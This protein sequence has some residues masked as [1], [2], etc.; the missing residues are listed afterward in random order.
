MNSQVTPGTVVNV[1]HVMPL[2]ESISVTIGIQCPG[3]KYSDFQWAK[4][5]RDQRLTFTDRRPFFMDPISIPPLSP[6]NC[7]VPD[8]KRM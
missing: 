1:L 3:R 5:K 4:E 7:C 6:W 8:A 2:S